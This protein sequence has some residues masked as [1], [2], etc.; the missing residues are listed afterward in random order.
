MTIV[1]AENVIYGSVLGAGLIAD[2]A[3]DKDSGG[4]LPAVI[5][6]H[7]GRWIRGS[8]FDD[9]KEGRLDNGVIDLRQ[10]AEAGFFAMRIDYRLVT[11]SPA[12][13]CFQDAMCAVRWV[14]AHAAQYGIDEDRIV[15]IGQSAGGHLAALAATAGPLLFEPTGGWEGN[16][17]D[18]AAALS[19]AGAYDLVTLDWG[20]GWCLPGVP[21]DVARRH[22]SPL[23]HAARR[24]R[25]ML[26]VHASDDPSVPISQADVFAS[27]L[28][29]VGA[30]HV[31]RRYEVGGHLKINQNVYNDCQNFIQR[32]ENRARRSS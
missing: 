12:P 1:T 22:A 27:K 13:A 15:L 6:I 9:G 4:L 10:W 28:T 7:G 18:F 23:R 32:G 25:P 2:I 20:S 26:I 21:W 17:S 19:I 31:Y 8:R 11:G 3:F 16:R 24:S 29:E 14:H 5:S 30:P